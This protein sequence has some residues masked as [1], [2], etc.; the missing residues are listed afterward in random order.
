MPDECEL[1]RDKKWFNELTFLID[2][3]G[4]LNILIKRLQGGQNLFL[5]FVGSVHVFMSRIR[6]FESNLGMGNSLCTIK[7]YL[8]ADYRQILHL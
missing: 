6:L 7:I 8:S 1:L 2:I 3:L 4:H 5:L